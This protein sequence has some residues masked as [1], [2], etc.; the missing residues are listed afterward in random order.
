MTPDQKLAPL[1][2]LLRRSILYLA[3]VAAFLLFLRHTEIGRAMNQWTNAVV[4]SVC[5][6]VL[7]GFSF[8]A[9]TE[10][11]FIYAQSFTVEIVDECNG[12]LAT[13]LLVAACLSYPASWRHRFLGVLSSILFVFSL[14]QIRLVSVM[15]VGT[16]H[17]ESVQF[18]E[19]VFIR[20]IHWLIALLFFWFWA[21]AG[22]K[23]KEE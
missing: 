20:A 22:W 10:G 6:R 2:P 8:D 9:T 4:A 16:Y 5:S 1:L 18:F 15:L 23:T 19:E 13:S 11:R 21:R 14:N 7:R 17:R 3:L 12:L